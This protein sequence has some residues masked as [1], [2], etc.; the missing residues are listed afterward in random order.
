M[1][2]E[3]AHR[4]YKVRL[5]DWKLPALTRCVL[6][7]IWSKIQETLETS[8]SENVKIIQEKKIEE[9]ASNEL[10]LA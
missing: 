1:E 6:I 10:M 7:S 3:H 4:K 5:A 9:F 2:I 8:V